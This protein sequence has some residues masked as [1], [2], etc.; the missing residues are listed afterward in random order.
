MRAANFRVA[1]KLLTE[2][3]IAQQ[4]R[5]TAMKATSKQVRDFPSI[6]SQEDFLR[7]ASKAANFQLLSESY[8]VAAIAT[9]ISAFRSLVC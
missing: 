9:L 7:Q 8:F 5:Q 1:L 6:T 4:F 3:P 2:Q